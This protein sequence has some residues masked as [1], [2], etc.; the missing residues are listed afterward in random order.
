MWLHPVQRLTLFPLAPQQNSFRPS[1]WV[2]QAIPDS[3]ASHGAPTK[4]HLPGSEI[5]QRKDVLNEE[6][7]SGESGV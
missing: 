3:T 1:P 5:L 6:N 2:T 4:V 7:S